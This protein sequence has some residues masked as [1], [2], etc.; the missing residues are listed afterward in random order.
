M[1]VVEILDT[2]HFDNLNI[3]NFLKKFSNLC[4]KYKIINVYKIIKL[5][6]YCDKLIEDFVKSSSC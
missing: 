1:F 4:N 5:S 3:I 6:R 2:S